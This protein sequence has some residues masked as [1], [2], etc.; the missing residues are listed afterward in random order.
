MEVDAVR[1]D[2]TRGA[3]LLLTTSELSRARVAMVAEDVLASWIVIR[4]RARQYERTELSYS[5]LI[6]SA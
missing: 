2:P 6:L 5:L 3:F 4:V 1:P